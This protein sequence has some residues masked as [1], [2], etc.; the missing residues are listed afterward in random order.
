MRALVA[1][2]AATAVAL[3]PGTAASAAA[4]PRADLAPMSHVAEGTLG[5]DV[6]IPLLI[7]N[8][9]PGIVATATAFIEITVPGG[10]RITYDGDFQPPLCHW[11]IPKRKVRC[12]N[13][14]SI[15]PDTMT[16][17]TVVGPVWFL[18]HF[19]VLAKCVT[20][21]SYRL[22]YS[23]D[24]KSS[25]NSTPLRIKVKGVPASACAPKAP[26]VVATPTPTPSP[27]A[28]TVAS[29]TPTATSEE[30]LGPAATATVSASAPPA[31]LLRTAAVITG[32]SVAVLALAGAGLYLYTRRRR[33]TP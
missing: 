12:A 16:N 22:V 18:V 30:P 4:L 31:P 14:T 21:G 15:L 9:G 13:G 2:I 26:A 20:P 19:T 25:N 11:L 10:A 7:H 32:G 17:S 29:P 24:P 27:S 8:Y 1:V 28:S 23:N 33:P 6:G 3:A 5:H